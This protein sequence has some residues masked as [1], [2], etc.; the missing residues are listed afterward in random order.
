MALG[1]RAA[2]LG[3]IGLLIVT[4]TIVVLVT[5]GWRFRMMCVRIGPLGLLVTNPT[6]TTPVSWG[7]IRSASVGDPNAWFWT[8][9]PVLNLREGGRVS[10]P[11]LQSPNSVTR[12]DNRFGD[13]A[14][15]FINALIDLSAITDQEMTVD[16]IREIAA[17]FEMPISG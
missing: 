12:P 14:S 8:G 17:K 1:G 4:P 6:K 7:E 16:R 11:S 3:A 5:I 2:S 13:R 15:D 9:A 10:M